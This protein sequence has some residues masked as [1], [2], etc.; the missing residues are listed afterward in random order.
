MTVLGNLSVSVAS[1]VA[2]AKAGA[3]DPLLHLVA[4]GNDVQKEKAAGTLAN[5][6]HNADNKVE[7]AT[8]GGIPLLAALLQDGT[9]PQQEVAAR[10]LRNLSLGAE[11]G[12]AFAESGAIDLLVRLVQDGNDFLKEEAAGAL[13]SL[14]QGTDTAQMIAA[15]GGIPLL[16]T[17]LHV[18]TAAQ[19]EKAV[20]A[21][22]TLSRREENQAAFATARAAGPVLG[23][24]RIGSDLQETAV[25]TVVNLASGVE[26]ARDVVAA[27]GVPLLVSLPRDG[28]QP[29][30]GYAMLAL[31][32]LAVVQPTETTEEIAKADAI[33]L[34]ARLM[35]G[36]VSELERAYSAE[37]LRCVPTACARSDAIGM[38]VA[39]PTLV[40][41]ASDQ[42]PRPQELAAAAL[43]NLAL[44]SAPARSSAIA[45]MGGV[46]A[47]AALLR[48]RIPSRARTNAIAALMNLATRPEIKPAILDAGTIILLMGLP[49]SGERE[50]GR[51]LAGLAL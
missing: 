3:I 21:L 5:L 44:T 39:I 50:E 8:S 49:E 17:L 16:V 25:A 13:A 42:S 35:E 28:P 15:G 24:V 19:Q 26:S 38:A 48:G 31:C 23:L 29:Q 46:D 43:A 9:E 37:I 41:L 45:A 1:E 10:A 34:L 27:G 6:A 30:K 11:N 2:I 4:S 36:G 20:V 7:I 40:C 51:A 12:A 18:G 14:S 32:N 22:C 47:L 33:P